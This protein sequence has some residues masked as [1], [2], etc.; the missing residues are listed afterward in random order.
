MV[1][2]K[3][4]RYCT[5]SR[6]CQTRPV[7]GNPGRTTMPAYPEHDTPE[8]RLEFLLNTGMSRMPTHEGHGPS[9]PHVNPNAYASTYTPLA[10]LSQFSRTS[11]VAQ[12]APTL[13]SDG[14]YRNHGENASDVVR[15]AV[16]TSQQAPHNQVH[17]A[18]TIFA[19]RVLSGNRKTP[20]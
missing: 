20:V 8:A 17:R 9:P 3:T 7:H 14:L 18:R 1:P 5:V 10:S 12:D 13:Q 2:S 15:V 11:M 6:Q 4:Q 19:R 16:S